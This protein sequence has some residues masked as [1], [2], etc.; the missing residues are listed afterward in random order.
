MGDAIPNLHALSHRDFVGL[1]RGGQYRIL[2]NPS[3][4]P[5][6]ARKAGVLPTTARFAHILYLSLIN[7]L[8][9]VGIVLCLRSPVVGGL[10]V[11]LSVIGLILQHTGAGELLARHAVESEQTY[12]ALV[13]GNHIKLKPLGGTSRSSESTRSARSEP[14][15]RSRAPRGTSEEA[16]HAHVLGLSGKTTMSDVKAAYRTRIAEYHPDRVSHLGPKLRALAEEEC[17]Q[18]NA[19]YEF[20]VRKYGRPD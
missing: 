17:K 5:Q 7:V 16:R 10:I 19:A 11:V 12:R 18:I 13:Q 3:A 8:L 15:P 1:V 20:F 2:V 6:L 9:V 14:P 4:A